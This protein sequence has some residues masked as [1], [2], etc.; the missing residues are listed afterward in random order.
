MVARIFLIEARPPERQWLAR[1]LAQAA[2]MVCGE[3]SNRDE[4][5][6]LLDPAVADLIILDLAPGGEEGLD[7][8]TDLVGRGPALLVYSQVE[9]GETIVRAFAAGATGYVSKREE[10][11][12]LLTGVAQLLGKRRYI[13]PRVT[14]TLADRILAAEIADQG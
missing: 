10:T 6:A 5:L 3:A 2:Y 12:I 4:A 13:S 9:D 1:T 7:L 11:E 8:I 14:H